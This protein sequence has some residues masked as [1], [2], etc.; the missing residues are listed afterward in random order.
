MKHSLNGFVHKNFKDEIIH[1]PRKI[2]SAL[3]LVISTICLLLLFCG[4][5][6]RLV[7]IFVGKTPLSLTGSGHTWVQAPEGGEL[8]FAYTND[9]FNNRLQDSSVTEVDLFLESTQVI[10]SDSARMSDSTLTYW[11]GDKMSSTIISEIDKIVIH[12]LIPWDRGIKEYI[13][14]NSMLVGILGAITQIPKKEGEKFDFKD[15]GIGAGIGA[16]I[17]AGLGIL[18]TIKQRP[19]ETILFKNYTIHEY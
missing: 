5:P 16:T 7:S 9:S 1:K 17:G 12:G 8:L 10:E 2:V 19:K 13:P 14:M 3:C 11:I 18:G 4:C 15:I 6:P